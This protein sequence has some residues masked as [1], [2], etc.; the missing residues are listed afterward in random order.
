MF[1]PVM[2]LMKD[3]FPAPVMPMTAI[4]I[5]FSLK[6]GG[7]DFDTKFQSLLTVLLGLLIMSIAD[8]TPE[9]GVEE[10]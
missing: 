7:E 3:V 6:T 9:D 8:G 2:S 1:N 10:V 5:D 4:K